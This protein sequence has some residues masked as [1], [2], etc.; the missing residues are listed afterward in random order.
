[1]VGGA[2]ARPG[3]YQT[4][5]GRSD[6]I[7]CGQTPR[8][9]STHAQRVQR[10]QEEKKMLN[11]LQQ[12]FQEYSILWL[13]VSSILGGIIGASMR[14][15]FEVIL[16]QQ[17]QQ[18]RQVI[19]VKRKYA[20]P[21]LFFGWLQILRRTV[22]Y[23]DFTTTK[24]TQKYE[25][26]LEAIE[27]GFSDPSLFGTSRT[28]YPAQTQD[29][30][31]FTFQIQAIGASMIIREEKEYRTLDY[32]SFYKAFSESENVEFRR[33]FAPLGRMFESLKVEDARFRRIIAIHAILNAFIENIDPKH[34]RTE[35]HPCHWELLSEEEMD[36][37]RQ[38]INQIATL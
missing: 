13:L 23:L 11:W 10:K 34:L 30:W 25:R 33:W 8:D 7:E 14:F 37:I 2:V 16:P 17:L 19:A 38:Q 26:F 9:L 28:S 36:S 32:A 6:N 18:R 31:I 22:V 12:S 4:E 35:K 27:N 21:I 29:Q 5:L 1:M 24:E 3:G 15:V 20:T